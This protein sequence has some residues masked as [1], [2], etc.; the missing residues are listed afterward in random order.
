[1]SPI[2]RHPRLY[3]A[4]TALLL[5]VF[6]QG[7]MQWTPVPLEP[8]RLTTGQD[9][10]VTLATGDRRTLRGAYVAR[11]SLVSSSAEP[12]PLA[13]I[14][15]IERHTADGAATGAVVATGVVALVVIAVVALN[16]ALKGA[17]DLGCFP[18]CN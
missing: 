17:G 15:R 2:V 9:V 11:D 10:R 1:M 14:T 7:C 5:T 12:I 18:A 8:Q 16:G 13:R 4:A 6:V 3:R